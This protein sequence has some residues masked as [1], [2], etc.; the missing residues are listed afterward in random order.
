MLAIHVLFA[1]AAVSVFGFFAFNLRKTWT[2]ITTVGQGVEEPRV[3]ELLT[4]IGR[5]MHGG[6]IQGRM[7]KDLPAG[8]MHFFIFWGFVMVSLGTIETMLVGIVPNFHLVHLIGQTGFGA[9]LA[10]QDI[11]NAMVFVSIIYAFARRILFTPKR[12]AD[13]KKDSRMDAYI[14]LGS[15]LG[16]V[17]TAMLTM[18][19]KAMVGSTPGLDATYLPLSTMLTKLVTFPIQ[20]SVGGLTIF[21]EV[22]W[23]LHVLVL[24]GFTTFLPYSKHQHLIWVWPNMFF[25]SHKSTGRLRPMEFD[26]EAES[27]GVGDAN[28]FTWKQLLDSMACVE[29][30]RCTSVCP[31]ASTDK[32]LDPR[33]IVHHLKEAMIDADNQEDTSKRQ[34]LIGGVVER[35]ELW[36]CTTCGAC[37]EACPLHIEHIPAIVDMR[38]YMTMTEG[39]M[40]V[41]LQTTL[42]NLENQSNPWGM[43]NDSRADWA[44]G[45]DVPT[46]AEKPDAEYLFW[47]GCAGSFDERYK[48]VSQSIAKILNQAEVSFAILGSEEQCNGDTARRSGNEYLAQAQIEANIETFKRYGVK[49]V[50]TGCPHCFNTIKNEYPD[51]GFE[52]GEVLHHSELIGKLQTE[53]KL[54]TT[55]EVTPS[56]G[57]M[58]YHD[59]C[60][61]GR[62]NQVYAEPRAA[63]EKTAGTELVEMERNRE[64]G[65][66]CGAGGARMWMEET[67]GSRINVNRAEE[68][69]A[70]GASSVATACPFCMTMM[71]DGIKAKGKEDQVV[72][73]DIAEVVA[74]SL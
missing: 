27:F 57:T 6:L 63:L 22:F 2:R 19:A 3:D 62:H 33:K 42:Q 5:V 23:W 71:Q 50:V 37:M 32:P 1:L 17:T 49:K 46:M 39:E 64:N 24:F 11:A 74:S 40:P 8:I 44:K 15:I 65:F 58:T 68:A 69:L 43:S 48:K 16:L 30:G 28:G 13:L 53:G 10:S 67:I 18:G 47:V 66:C 9:F 54:K 35:D 70:T 45:H 7:F 73:K 72:V 20:H 4:R 25:K 61:L 12:L 38:R 31:A 56:T 36:S 26:E 29:C 55:K 59:S 60:Y 51:F 14:V 41:E 21:G 34:T 52:V